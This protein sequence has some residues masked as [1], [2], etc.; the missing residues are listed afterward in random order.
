MQIVSTQRN[1]VIS[2]KKVR[3]VADQIKKLSPAKALEVLP[4][5]QKRGAGYIEKVIKSAMANAK[6]KGI[7]PDDLVIKEIQIGDAP[8]L[9]R[10]RP[11]SRGMWHPYVKKMSHIRVV[12]ETRNE[13]ISNPKKQTKTKSKTNS[14]TN[15]KKKNVKSN[16]TNK[17]STKKGKK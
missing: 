3:P 11:V 6:Q 16:T 1:L 8:R 14:K 12:L 17:N 9:K 15:S 7:S 2:P 10:G 13:Q 4:L 5:V